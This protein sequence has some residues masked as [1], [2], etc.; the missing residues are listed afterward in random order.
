MSKSF[1]LKGNFIYC[2]DKKELVICE[3]SYGICVDGVS[4]GIYKEIPEKFQNLEIIDYGNCLILPGLVDLHVHG[5]QYGFRGVGFDHELIEWLNIHTFPV[6][7]QFRN[8]DYAKKAYKIFVE[9]LKNSATTRAVIF[10]TIHEKSTRILMELLEETGLQTY[11]GKVNMDRN[12]PEYYIEDSREKSV[13]DTIRFIEEVQKDF[14]NTK[15]IITP[16]FI[17]T[18]TDELMKDLAE[19]KRRYHLPM[20]SHLSENRGE[21]EWVKELCP[22]AECY[23]D[24]YDAS[25]IL[26]GKYSSIMAHCVSSTDEEIELLKKRE[27]FV[28]HCPKS[29]LNLMSGIAPI[30]KYMKKEIPIG[31]GSDVAGGETLSIFEE[32]AKAIQVSK[33]YWR[34]IDEQCRPLTVPEALFLATRGGGGFFGNVG[35]F[36]EGFEFDAIVIDDSQIK[37]Q[38]D[39]TL[40]ER[41]ERIVY[42]PG[43]CK[44]IAKAVGGKK[45]FADYSNPKY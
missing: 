19:L 4:E 9:D 40:A 18:C 16:R 29:N 10:G 23:G 33:M 6:E 1:I 41:L 8:E 24:A 15:P 12:A 37:T 42:S 2:N 7:S 13:Q 30:R 34:Y 32:M 28:A 21:I 27:V 14:K 5:P 26:E 44:I 20:Q 38:L 43:Q 45:I 39:L 22:W 36:E 3:N 11:V 35:S 25:G 17:P 31:L